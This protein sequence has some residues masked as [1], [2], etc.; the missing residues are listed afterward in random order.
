MSR[1]LH[2]TVR[3]M[4]E[5]SMALASMLPSAPDDAATPGCNVTLPA[6]TVGTGRRQA[7]AGGRLTL[8]PHRG[9]VVAIALGPPSALGI[10]RPAPDEA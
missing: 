9:A 10:L 8:R 7:E 5:R 2:G 1:Y 6:C 3:G 4:A